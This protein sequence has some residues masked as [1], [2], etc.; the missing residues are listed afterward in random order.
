MKIQLDTVN[1]TITIEEDVNLHEFYEE[2]NAILPG[3]LWREFTLKV[4]VIKKFINPITPTTPI[5]PFA[6]LDPNPSPYTNPYPPSY[7][8]IWYTTATDNSN[9]T[10]V[11]S[12][13]YNIKTKA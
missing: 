3:G 10:T 11:N 5:N 9:S 7:P 1:K 6:P 8:Q 4:G 13:I 2:I 12:G